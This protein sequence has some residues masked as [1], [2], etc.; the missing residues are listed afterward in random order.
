MW[1]LSFQKMYLV[2][3]LESFGFSARN[4]AFYDWC[5]MFIVVQH[6]MS[7]MNW[8]K[9]SHSILTVKINKL[10]QFLM[11]KVVL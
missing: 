9:E 8:K 3:F 11:L 7:N 2:D 4:P 6:L 5:E 10:P 1:H